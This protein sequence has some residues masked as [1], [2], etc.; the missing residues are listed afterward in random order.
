MIDCGYHGND[1]SAALYVTVFVHLLGNLTS[2][3]KNEGK[4]KFVI[5]NFPTLSQRT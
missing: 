5:S 3:K 2:H 4:L 1:K